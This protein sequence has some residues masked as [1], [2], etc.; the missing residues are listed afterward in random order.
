MNLDIVFMQK[1]QRRADQIAGFI[2]HQTPPGVSL[3]EYRIFLNLL[4]EYS[5]F[6]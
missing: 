3:E 2:D 4:N 1:F 6:K 5:N